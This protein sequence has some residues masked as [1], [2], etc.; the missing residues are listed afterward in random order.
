M[1][2]DTTKLI[3]FEK[4]ENSSVLKRPWEA[5]G[6]VRPPPSVIGVVVRRVARPL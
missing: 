2:V 6:A 5:T 1:H 4:Q 3:I